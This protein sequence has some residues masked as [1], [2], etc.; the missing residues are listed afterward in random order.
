MEKG[1]TPKLNKYGKR[2]PL[3]AQELLIKLA[4]AGDRGLMAQE[5]GELFYSGEDALDDRFLI[6][7][8]WEKR[9]I[10][11]GKEKGEKAWMKICRISELGKGCLQRLS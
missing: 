7:W 2:L 4:E 1:S 10:T 11:E 6:T 3:K 5:M 9:E 8:D